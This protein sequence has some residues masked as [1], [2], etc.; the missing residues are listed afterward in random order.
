MTSA[1]VRALII[2]DEPVAREYLQDLLH[3]R[4]DVS[5]VGEAANGS[6]AVEAIQ[7]ERPDLIFLDI[8]MPEL[9]GFDVLTRLSPDQLPV[10]IFVT[11]HDRYALQ[12]FE[13]NALDYLLKPF[14]RPRFQKALDRA[15]AQV[16]SRDLTAF[17][18]RLRSLV[19]HLHTD[20]PPTQR[21]MIRSRGRAHFVKTADILF[22]EAAG[23]YAALHVGGEEHLIR[24]TL[25]SLERRLDPESFVRIHRSFIVNLDHVR[26]VLTQEKGDYRIV[27]TDG[28]HLRLGRSYRDNLL[29]RF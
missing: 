18:K 19:N 25:S 11:A 29:A 28:R 6:E 4:E 20:R 8:Q 10:I 14:D 7:R 26:E 1:T 15:V 21:L 9:D 27:V 22:I 3:E 16:Q 13:A 12:A 23:N 2:D 24:E 5:V 17:E